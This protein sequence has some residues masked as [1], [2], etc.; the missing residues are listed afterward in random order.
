MNFSRDPINVT[1]YVTFKM[2]LSKIWRKKSLIT[3][4]FFQKCTNRVCVGKEKKDL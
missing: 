4:L 2:L 3:T 1:E